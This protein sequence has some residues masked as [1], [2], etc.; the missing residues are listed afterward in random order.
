MTAVVS[1][2][3]AIGTQPA[4]SPNQVFILATCTHYNV[5]VPGDLEALPG[6]NR[7]T[8]LELKPSPSDPRVR[9]CNARPLAAA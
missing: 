5:L 3:N 1:Q 8:P 4:I 6:R 2:A 9:T 7:T